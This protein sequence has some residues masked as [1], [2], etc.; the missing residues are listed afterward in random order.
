MVDARLLRDGLRYWQRRSDVVL[1]E[2]A[3]GLMSPLT[4]DE[5]NADLAYDLGMPLVVVAKNG[6]GTINHVLQ[7]LVAAATFCEGLAV[8]G[9]V[10]N[11]TQP[12]GADAPD[13][14]GGGREDL[15]VRDAAG[16]W[17]HLDKPSLSH[18]K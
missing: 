9:I 14:P 7:T 1:V 2:G 6:L 18:Y 10:L 8:A 5:Y 3:G 17:R 12:R 13:H 11:E 4:D 15:L 16:A